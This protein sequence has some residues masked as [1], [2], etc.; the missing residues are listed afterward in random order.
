M[1]ARLPAIVAV[2]NGEVTR[3]TGK[4]PKDAIKAISVTQK[5]SSTIPG[6]HVGLEERKLPSG[7]AFHYLY[8]PGELEG[9]LHRATDP[10]WSLIIYRL[11]R[12]VTKPGEPVLYYLLDGPPRGLVLEGILVVAP[13]TQLPSDGVLPRA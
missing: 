3:L 10:V 12:S 2:L 1:V 5:P 4:M 6:R 13:D 11:G 9:G 8:Q 7:V